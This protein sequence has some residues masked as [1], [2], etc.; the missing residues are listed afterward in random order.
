M[1]ALNEDLYSRI[2]RYHEFKDS[3]I[4]QL[5]EIS[6]VS[7]DNLV[8][9]NKHQLGESPRFRAQTIT[10]RK[11]L[12]IGSYDSKSPTKDVQVDDNYVV[13]NNHLTEV[14]CQ[15]IEPFYKEKNY[16]TQSMVEARKI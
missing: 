3:R 9:I 5:A 4:S 16:F 2:D 12:H 10:H 13:T 15:P 1:H 6:R 14:P 7:P 11:I 8:I